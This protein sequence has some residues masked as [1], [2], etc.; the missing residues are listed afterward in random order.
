MYMYIYYI[1][2]IDNFSLT[3]VGIRERKLQN[4]FDKNNLDW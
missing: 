4:C 3:L 1:Q 2:Y